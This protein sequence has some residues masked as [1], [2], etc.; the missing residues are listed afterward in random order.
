[1]VESLFFIS[2]ERHNIRHVD[3][4]TGFCVR[5]DTASFE[6]FGGR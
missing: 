4:F 3:N 6:S 2:L 5:V 1:M